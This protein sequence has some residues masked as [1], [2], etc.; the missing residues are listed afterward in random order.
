MQVD[1]VQNVTQFLQLYDKELVK[2]SQAA[3]KATANEVIKYTLPNTPK[4]V[5]NKKSASKSTKEIKQNIANLQKRI[6]ANIT[7]K[8]IPQALPTK[9]GIII[10][11][12]CTAPTHLPYVVKRKNKK[13]QI[14]PTLYTSSPQE[15]VKHLEENTVINSD[16]TASRRS[17][18][19]ARF[20]WVDSTKTVNAAASILAKRA[21]NLLS[22]WNA[23]LNRINAMK[24]DS[25]SLLSSVLPAT[26][27]VG[28]KGS[29]SVTA[30]TSKSTVK[31][32]NDEVE[33]ATQG[34]QQRVVDKGIQYNFNK[35]L[36]NYISRINTKK[37]LQQIQN[38]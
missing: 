2:A 9:T 14:I 34:Y 38:V 21:G 12:T 22:G 26:A 13:N 16:K 35:H 11:G 32:S 19:G 36:K 5:D 17:K 25:T 3:I 29:S 20:M 33:A 28:K 15:L 30:T 23:L 8:K 18:K 10:K 1:I 6:K 37:I 4:N 31:A 27:T 7:G 24:G